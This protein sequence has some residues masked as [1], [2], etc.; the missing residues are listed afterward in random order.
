[1]LTRLLIFLTLA[2][3]ALV[4]QINTATI[5]GSVTDGTGATVPAAA[6]KLLNTGTQE[7]HETTSDTSG[8]YIFDRVPVGELRSPSRRRDSSSLSARMCASTPR[9]A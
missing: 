2:C 8:S 7:T 6:I 9:S 3:S 4:G 5:L 1:M